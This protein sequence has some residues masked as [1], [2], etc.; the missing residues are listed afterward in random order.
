MNTGI[1][2]LTEKSQV[3]ED[4][5]MRSLEPEA[6]Q[7]SPE[8]NPPAAL[9]DGEPWSGVRPDTAV[10]GRSGC[11]VNKNEGSEE[12]VS[13]PIE[14]GHRTKGSVHTCS[15]LGHNVVHKGCCIILGVSCLCYDTRVET[16]E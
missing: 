14:E 9:S 3:S 11:E 1:D 15:A 12:E 4:G 6:S 2:K 16:P 8:G 10:Q 5:T 13:W 7:L